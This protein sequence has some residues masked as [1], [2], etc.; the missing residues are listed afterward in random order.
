VPAITFAVLTR[1]RLA[2]AA[3]SNAHNGYE[4]GFMV[5]PIQELQQRGVGEIAL[6]REREVGQSYGVGIEPVLRYT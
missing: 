3:N 5:A 2:P 4:R 6:A 1:G